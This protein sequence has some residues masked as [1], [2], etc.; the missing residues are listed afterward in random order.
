MDAAVNFALQETSGFQHAEMFRD[1]RKGDRE[2]SCEFLD[3]SSASG[4]ARE[5]GAAR[6]VGQRA[7]GDVQRRGGI[8]NHTVYYY[9]A[10]KS[11]QVGGFSELR[12]NLWRC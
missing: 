2:R 7:E 10:A 1:G 11:C 9:T 3:G 4:E 5:N 12:R 6:G 8:V